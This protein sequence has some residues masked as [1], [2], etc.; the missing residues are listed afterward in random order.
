MFTAWGFS[1]KKLKKIKIKLYFK[2]DRTQIGK[3]AIAPVNGGFRIVS[4]DNNADGLNALKIRY[5]SFS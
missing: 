4:I 3:D 1:P 2:F 5:L